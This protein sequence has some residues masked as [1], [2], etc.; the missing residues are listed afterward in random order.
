[1]SSLAI[2]T[3]EVNY[4]LNLD[5]SGTAFTAS[6]E[7]KPAI[8]ENILFSGVMPLYYNSRVRLSFSIADE[9]TAKYAMI[10]GL[11]EFHRSKHFSFQYNVKQNTIEIDS[12]ERQ[13]PELQLFLN[14]V[15]LWLQQEIQF[16]NTLKAVL[17]F[18]SEYKLKRAAMYSL[19]KRTT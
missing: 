14:N 6:Q 7:T 11:I 4:N 9:F 19:L 13:L 10:K 5:S 15:S 2:Q 16:R 1:M 17:H 18:E 8:F 3:Q 12:D